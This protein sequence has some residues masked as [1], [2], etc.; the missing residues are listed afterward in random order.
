MG[1]PLVVLVGPPGSGK[2]TIGRRL[3]R[4][5]QVP[6]TD[7]D[8]LIEE[9]ENDTCGAVFSR[10]GEPAFRQLE[11]EVVADALQRD[12]VVSLGGGAVLSERTRALLA[13]HAVVYLNVTVEEGVRRTMIDNSR[14]V[15]ECENP[16][17]RYAE[18]LSQRNDLYHEV[19]SFK[20]DSD[21]RSPQRVVTEV[22]QYLDL[23]GDV[24]EV[25]SN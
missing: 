4:A 12:G 21:S 18:I 11:E 23:V 25:E 7:T 13:E 8:F 2:S 5:L 17:E 14:P 10:L 16:I 24:D 15:L 6:L 20:V 9:R 22:L 1:S 19:A 3:S